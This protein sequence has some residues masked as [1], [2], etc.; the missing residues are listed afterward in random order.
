MVES[1]F[2]VSKLFFSAYIYPVIHVEIG[3]KASAAIWA[4]GKATL[5]AL[6]LL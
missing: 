5:A 6:A 2:F 3:D 1:V 4:G